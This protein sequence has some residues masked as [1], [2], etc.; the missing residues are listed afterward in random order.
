MNLEK[1]LLIAGLATT[2]GLNSVLGQNTNNTKEINVEIVPG[3]GTT[4]IIPQ[5]NAEKSLTKLNRKATKEDSWVYYKDCLIDN[6]TNERSDSVTTQ[7]PTITRTIYGDTIEVKFNEGDTI[8]FY[9][10]HVIPL[11]QA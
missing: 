1:Y 4:Y 7:F 6:G 3:V 9:H 10:N 11:H 5:K 2:L 8:T